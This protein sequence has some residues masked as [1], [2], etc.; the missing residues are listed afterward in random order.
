[1][2]DFRVMGSML[3]LVSWGRNVAP[4]YIKTGTLFGSWGSGACSVVKCGISNGWKGNRNSASA[5]ILAFPRLEWA[6]L[7]RTLTVLLEKHSTGAE[8]PEPQPLLLRG[9]CVLAA[10][11]RALFVTKPKLSADT[12]CRKKRVRRTLCAGKFFEGGQFVPGIFCLPL[13]QMS[14]WT[15]ETMSPIDRT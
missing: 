3:T 11:V 4:P 6:R 8:L 1:M 15:F 2:Q 14:P 5:F 13:E 10:D 7:Q 12:S 9:R